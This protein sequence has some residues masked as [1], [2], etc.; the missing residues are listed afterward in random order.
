MTPRFRLLLASAAA[1]ALSGASAHA[2]SPATQPKA[3]VELF[4][5]QGCSSCPPAD[6]LFVE[7]SKN[8]E[9]IVLTL[10]VTY[11][12]Y[13]G[14][15]DTLGQEAFTRRQKFYAK[16]RG[17]GQVYT[18]Q[19]VINGASHMVG[20]DGAEIDRQL[21]KQGATGLSVKIQLQEEAGAL[22]IRLAATE[23]RTGGVWLLPTLRSAVVP[24]GRG[25]NHG[26]TVS[27]ANV[28]RGMVKI[29]EWDGREAVLTAPLAATRT[30]DSDGYVVIVQADQPTRYGQMPGVI[31][32]AARSLR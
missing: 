21:R 28:V 31:I 32:G 25:E 27:Y 17:D 16:A 26:R 22:T 12:D 14:W 9:I 18:P 13:L 3:V 7:L 20:S 2:Q 4:T 19:A 1:L 29:A 10:P 23:G 5:S 6:A 11:W 24:I 8:P 30:A 15:K